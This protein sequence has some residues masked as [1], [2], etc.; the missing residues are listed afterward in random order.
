NPG[1]QRLKGYTS[2]EIIGQHFSRFYPSDKP[3][4]VID[5]ELVT[6]STTGRFREEGW[7]V[8][9]DGSR[10]WADVTITP[11]RDASGSVVG[12]AKVNRDMTDRKEADGATRHVGP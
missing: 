3:R 1:A 8:R 2:S 4:A 7:R 12:Y 9:K 6:A 10:F 11:I 5:Q